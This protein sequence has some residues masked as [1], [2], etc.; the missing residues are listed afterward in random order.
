MDTIRRVSKPLAFASLYLASVAALWACIGSSKSPAVAG[1]D[2]DSGNSSDSA[3]DDDFM[4]VD[5]SLMEAMGNAQ[6]ALDDQTDPV[7]LCLTQQVLSFNL[8][9]AYKPGQGVAPSWSSASPYAAATTGHSALDDLGLAGA[10]GG[11]YCSAEVYGNN[12]TETAFDAVLKDLATV[13]AGELSSQ[14][15]SGYD[16]ELYF[17]LR[18]AQTAYN[19]FNDSFATTLGAAADTFGAALQAQAYTVAASGSGDAGSPGGVVIGTRNGDGSVSYAPAQTVMAAAALLDMA[20]RHVGDTDAGS[21]PATWEA[22]AQQVLTY[23]QARARDPQTGLYYQALVTSADPGHDALGTASPTN[24]ALLTD[25]QAWVMLGFARAQD[26]L[27]T[28]QT[29]PDGGSPIFDSGMLPAPPYWIAGSDLATAI[30]AAGLF[31]GSTNPPTPPTP[32]TFMQG[33]LPSDGVV[34]TNKTSIGNAI[35]LGA[36]HRIATGY[37]SALSYELGE[38]RAG[39]TAITTCNTSLLSVVC[40]PSG[41]VQQA[42]LTAASKAYGLPATF[43]DDGGTSAPPAGAS[44]YQTEATI[45]AIEGFTQLWHGATHAASCAP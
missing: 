28:L 15:L 44:D 9:Y 36:F 8:Q 32:G 24:D 42:Y 27:T 29:P 7:A 19:T 17:R 25:T 12:Q 22:T 40:S 16:G 39:L 37:G 34:L 43:A 10:L 2:L 30:T 23:V 26:L 38:V 1:P 35:L 41:P 21:A 31:D 33:L 11:F 45:A 6:C 20:L 4:I 3:Y 18:W 13:L 5:E 14:P